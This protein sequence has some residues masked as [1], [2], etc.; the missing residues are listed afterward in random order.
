MRRIVRIALVVATLAASTTAGPPSLG[1]MLDPTRPMAACAIPG[2]VRFNTSA[3]PVFVPV[4]S[5]CSVSV[6]TG[7]KDGRPHQEVLFWLTHDPFQASGKELASV[8]IGADV[9]P[10]ADVLKLYETAVREAAGG[11]PVSTSRPSE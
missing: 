11:R 4:H 10:T 7:E 6:L 5:I 8:S 9:M 2:H 3:G 1:D